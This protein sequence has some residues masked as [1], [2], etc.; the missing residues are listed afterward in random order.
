MKLIII[1][2]NIFNINTEDKTNCS[3]IIEYQVSMKKGKNI[4]LQLK[5]MHLDMVFDRKRKITSYNTRWKKIDHISLQKYHSVS[6]RKAVQ[7]N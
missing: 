3:S 7:I 4:C 2:V 6:R 5:K 1:H